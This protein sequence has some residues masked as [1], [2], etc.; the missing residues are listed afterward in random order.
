VIW[1]ETMSDLEEVR[2]AIAGVRRVSTEIPLIT[3]MTFDTRGHTMMGVSPEQAVKTL[4]DW[5]AAAIGGNCGNGPDE[6]LGVI[7]KMYAVAP[8]VVLVSKSNAGIP[9]LVNGKAVYRATPE[10]MADYAVAVR[11]AGACI[12]GGCCGN[13]PAHIH[14]MAE[15]LEM[16]RVPSV[17]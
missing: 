5:G 1:I 16:N 10:N 15:A 9:E 4:R 12:I 3:T 14:A 2:A 8:D 13:T 7:Q 6:L 17:P 11:A